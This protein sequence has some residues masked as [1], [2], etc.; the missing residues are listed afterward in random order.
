MRTVNFIL[1]KWER[2]PIKPKSVNNR[3]PLSRWESNSYRP[4]NVHYFA[5]AKQFSFRTERDETQAVGKLY[6]GYVDEDGD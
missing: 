5:N 4:T 1:G 2:Q 6:K 3:K